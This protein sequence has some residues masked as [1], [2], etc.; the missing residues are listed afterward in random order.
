MIHEPYRRSAHR[1]DPP[2]SME[3]PLT[4][5]TIGDSKSQQLRASHMGGTPAKVRTPAAENQ[6]EAL[7]EMVKIEAKPQMKT[8]LVLLSSFVIA[9]A[10]QAGVCVG[11]DPCQACKDCSRCWYCSPKN[12]KSGSCSVIRNQKKEEADKRLK[13]QGA[14]RKNKGSDSADHSSAV[15]F[16]GAAWRRA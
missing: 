16:N 3:K 13:K 1:S 15:V 5:R 14:T 7:K 9:S 6:S 10:A 2:A 12:P 8:L 4:A 11:A